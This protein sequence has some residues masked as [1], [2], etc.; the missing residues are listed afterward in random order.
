MRL[1]TLHQLIKA[2][3]GLADP[4][5]ILVFGSSSLLAVHPDLGEQGRPLES[6]YD[7]DI[8]VRPLAQGMAAVLMDSIGRESLFAQES[9]YYADILHPSFP[10]GMPDGW[11]SRLIPFPGFAKAFALNPY[12]LALVKVI[13]ARPKDLELLRA[14]KPGPSRP[15]KTPHPLPRRPPPRTRSLHRLAKSASTEDVMAGFPFASSGVAV[16]TRK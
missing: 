4:E 16:S 12:D 5:T 6:S 7:A 2:I 1:R 15:G 3:E 8:L 10:D 9:G 13:L 14:V 11:E